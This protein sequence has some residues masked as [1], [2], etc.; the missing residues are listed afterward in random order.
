MSVIPDRIYHL[1][2]VLKTPVRQQLS[3]TAGRQSFLAEGV[4]WY[5]RST[6]CSTLFYF[7]HNDTSNPDS[8]PLSRS[9]QTRLEIRFKESLRQSVNVIIYA[10]KQKL[11]EIDKARNAVR[12]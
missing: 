8:I 7:G 4:C 3:E 9:G 10:R 2:A 12:Q 6:L 11:V 1:T 5:V